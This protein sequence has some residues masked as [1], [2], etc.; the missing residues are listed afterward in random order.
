MKKFNTL[1]S[2]A[3]PLHKK[4][5]DT[6]MI[7]SSD[8]IETTQKGGFGQH[9]FESLLQSDKKFPLHSDKYEKSRILITN[10]NFGGGSFHEYAVW[11]IQEAKFRVIIGKSFSNIFSANAA[12]N[13]LLLITLAPDLIDYILEHAEKEDY[14]IEVNLERETIKLPDKGK[15][16]FQYPEFRKHCLLN[17][18]DDLDYIMQ[19]DKEIAKHC[20]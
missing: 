19:S 18:V 7:I 11:A 14:K 4:D 12:K 15:Y 2:L 3:L 5:I 20:K 17:G 10:E 1:T 8:Y 13:G 6:S 9:L 16:K